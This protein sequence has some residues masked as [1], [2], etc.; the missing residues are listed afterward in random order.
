MSSKSTPLM[1]SS[2]LTASLISDGPS[3]SSDTVSDEKDATSGVQCCQ[4]RP[5]AG[6]P[7]CPAGPVARSGVAQ[8]DPSTSPSMMIRG[9]S[10]ST[11]SSRS[12][13]R[14]LAMSSIMAGKSSSPMWA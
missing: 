5:R 2:V 10:V 6:D 13:S 3:F 8:R 11:T 9:S 12:V 14:N 1:S 4:R 7:D